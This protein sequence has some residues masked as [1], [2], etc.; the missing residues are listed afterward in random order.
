LNPLNTEA[1]VGVIVDLMGDHVDALVGQ[2]DASLGVALEWLSGLAPGDARE[3][4]LRGILRERAGD[5][6]GAREFYHEALLRAPSEQMA[7]RRL[8]SLDIASGGTPEALGYLDVLLRRHGSLREALAP[9]IVPFSDAPQTQAAFEATLRAEPPWRDWAIGRLV[10]DPRGLD[11]VRR[12]VLAELIAGEEDRATAPFDDKGLKAVLGALVKA[13]QIVDAYGLFLAAYG[14]DGDGVEYVTNPRF[15]QVLSVGIFDWSL[16]RLKG[17]VSHMGR[18]SDGKSALVVRFSDSP[19]AGP[20]VS[21]LLFLP[22]GS[23]T[24]VVSGARRGLAAPRGL[25]LELGCDG[26]E[27]LVSVDLRGSDTPLFRAEVPLVAEDGC[28]LHKL[29]LTAG[30]H[31]LLRKDAYRGEVDI[32][33]VKVERRAQ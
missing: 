22:P 2:A 27:P 24:L 20:V 28:L 26:S 30:R 23:Y 14:R 7:L 11:F 12:L 15:D 3:A 5:E 9:L 33:E 10:A 8:L 17:A 25:A 4:S 1:R 13:G 18:G 32:F 31:A 29:T 19:F 16:S 6:A 21:Q